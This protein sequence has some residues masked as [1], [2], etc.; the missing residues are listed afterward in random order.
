[1]IAEGAAVSAAG[2]IGSAFVNNGLA[3]L[4]TSEDRRL[5]YMYNEMSA[6]NADVRTRALYNDFYSPAALMRQYKEA[7]LSPSLMFGG[8]P[9]QGGQ[10]GAQGNGSGGLQ[11]PYYPISAMEAAQM[12]LTL[13]E[14]KKTEAEK[15]NVIAD[16]LTKLNQ[17][18]LQD[19]ERQYKEIFNTLYKVGAT[20]EGAWLYDRDNPENKY[21]FYELA[22]RSDTYDNF[23]QTIRS[24]SGVPDDVNTEA[25]QRVLRT[26]YLSAKEL[27][28]ELAQLK[29]NKVSADFQ[30]S[31]INALQQQD[32]VKLNAQEA[33]QRL[34]T[35]IEVNSLTE[36]QKRA[37]TDLLNKIGEKGSTGRDIA[38]ILGMIYYQTMTT[39]TT[40]AAGA[41]GNAIGSGL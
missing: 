32:F 27:N 41:A 28:T 13:A 2:A 8:T 37:W 6:E 1:M 5:N 20:I 40:K 10:S 14:T 22:E 34:R 38:V 29:Y 39:L 7:G 9:G 31:L 16:T 15:E 26:I 33:V 24:K 19:L 18:Q 3:G 11:T 23:L 30:R 4:R 25:G 36:D 35:S 17:A 12:G 21:S